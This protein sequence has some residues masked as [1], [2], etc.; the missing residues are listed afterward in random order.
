MTGWWVPSS[1]PTVSTTQPLQ[2]VHFKKDACRG[3]IARISHRNFLNLSLRGSL[4]ILTAIFGAPS[5]HRKVPSPG[6][7]L[8]GAN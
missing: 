8:L 4:E 7:Y 5:P 2:T 3:V 1:S 6:A